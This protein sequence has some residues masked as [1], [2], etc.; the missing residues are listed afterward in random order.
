MASIEKLV[1]TEAPFSARKWPTPTF[2]ST[3]AAPEVAGLASV[4]V[5][6]AHGLS[7]PLQAIAE[8]HFVVSQ[9]DTAVKPIAA[10]TVPV[11]V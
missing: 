9:V 6:K 7:T 8:A 10:A 11:L 2:P 1:V 5:P 3:A 4:M